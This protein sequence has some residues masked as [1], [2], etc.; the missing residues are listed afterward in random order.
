V[1]VR[2]EEL[3]ITLKKIVQGLRRINSSNGIPYDKFKAKGVLF[4][5]GAM[6][7]KE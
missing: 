3:P 4:D 6:I 5:K 7:W 2:I 1:G